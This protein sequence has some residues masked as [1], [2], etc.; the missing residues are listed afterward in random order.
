MQLFGVV[1]TISSV[2]YCTQVSKYKYLRATGLFFLLPN[3][4]ANPYKNAY[5][6]FFLIYT[7]KHKKALILKI[8]KQVVLYLILLK[9]N[10]FHWK[11]RSNG[12]VNLFY[13]EIELVCFFE[14]WDFQWY[15]LT[16][17][18]V[19]ELKTIDGRLLKTEHLLTECF[20]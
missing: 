19:G 9:A 16:I 20:H 12:H 10:Y 7:R 3:K 14:F 2:Y 1:K 18:E 6:I 17:R 11:L 8:Y 5:Q 15:N 4:I 13:T